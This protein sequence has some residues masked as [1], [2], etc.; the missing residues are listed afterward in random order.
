MTT[1]RF[2]RRD[3][4]IG[5]GAALAAASS[6]AL[7]RFAHALM[8]REQKSHPGSTAA[9]AAGRVVLADLQVNRMGYGAMQFSG[10]QVWGNPI[11][12]AKTQRVL[13]R[14]IELGVNFIDTADA[15]G[16]ATSELAIAD[17]LYPYPAGLVIATKGGIVR[18]SAPEWVADA[19]PEHLRAACEASLKRLRLERIELYQLHATQDGVPVEDSVGELGKLQKEGKIRHIGVSNVTV[20]ELERARRV[21][22]VVAVQNGYNFVN[23][24][25]EDVL[26]YCERERIAFIPHT[27]LARRPIDGAQKN[28][29]TALES[30]AKTRGISMAQAALAWLLTRSALTLPIP[31]TSSVGH[32]EENVAAAAVKL[33]AEEMARVG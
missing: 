33:T 9:G 8:T 27:P 22:E 4:L 11:D 13:R 20:K 6:L 30:I 10:P 31:G 24:G 26:A 25:S 12:P 3:V 1:Q 7:P 14:A 15:Y 29:R 23:R 32:L 18:P 21:V 16:P 5:T 19:R 2:A 28:P 17:A